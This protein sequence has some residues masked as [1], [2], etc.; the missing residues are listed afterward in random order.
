MKMKFKTWVASIAMVG[1]LVGGSMG[2]AADWAPKGPVKLYIA[3]GAGGSTDTMGRIVAAQ[4]EES[5]GW[6]V[7]VENKPGGGGVAM[8]AGLKNAKP[9]GMHLGVAASPATLLNLAKRGDKMPFKVDSF[10]YLATIARGEMALVA[11]ADAPFNNMTE[12]IAQAKN[13]KMAIAYDGLPQQMIMAAV[14]NQAGVDFKFVKHKSGNEILQSVLGGHVDV[15]TPVGEHIKY[16][17]SGD[18]KML[19]AFGKERFSYAPE[20]KTLIEDGY[21]YYNNFHFYI[22]APKGLPDNVKQVLATT[23]DKA[24]NSDKARK[25]I[26]NTIKTD[27][28]NLGPEGTFQMMSEGLKDMK[29]LI[30]AGH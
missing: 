24:I 28:L 8:L 2:H 13:K 19:S 4:I 7:V 11:K 6:N 12:F 5:F 29:A 20:V 21:N 27:A 25:A 16:L 9:D 26:Q 17:K 18:M 23:L 30:E 22:V 1:F 15:G 10:D 3:F 14:K